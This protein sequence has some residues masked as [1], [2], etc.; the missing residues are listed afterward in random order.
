VT[1][2]KTD[3]R[4]SIVIDTREQTPLTFKRLPS[5]PGTLTS[6]DY[7]ILGLE[8]Q[9]AVERKSV[10]DL[11]ACCIGDNRERFERELH[12]LRGF[13]FAR[14]LIIGCEAE[15][16]THR[17]RSN[18]SPKSV[19]HTV[20]AFEARYV[21]VVWEPFPDKAAERI[22]QWGYWYARE[23]IK[24]AQSLATLQA[25]RQRNSAPEIQEHERKDT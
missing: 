15:I 24:A 10:P 11:V 12:R 1:E 6:G 19:L 8:N 18:I 7:S 4:L 16:T 17:Y 13:R 3:L 23:T 5:V 25:P 20:R 14:L 21:P 22:E 2:P 9:F